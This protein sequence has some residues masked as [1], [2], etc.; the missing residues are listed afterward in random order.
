MKLSSLL[1]AILKIYHKSKTLISKLKILEYC[2]LTVPETRSLFRQLAVLQDIYPDDSSTGTFHISRRRTLRHLIS[3]SP[4][5][6]SLDRLAL[7]LA[8]G[9]SFQQTVPLVMNVGN[10]FLTKIPFGLCFC[11]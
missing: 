10:P 3:C 9:S 7:G 4:L 6:L 11:Y 2:R 5:L 8:A 1:W